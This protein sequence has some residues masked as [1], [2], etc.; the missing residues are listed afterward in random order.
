[1]E[2]PGEL[3]ELQGQACSLERNPKMG[4]FLGSSP[5]YLWDKTMK[6]M[7][8]ADNFSSGWSLTITIGIRA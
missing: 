8:K 2:W 7:T 5:F 3:E 6:L 4:D 1:M